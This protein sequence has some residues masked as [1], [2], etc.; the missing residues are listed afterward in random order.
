MKKWTMRV[1]KGGKWV[2]EYAF[3]PKN[4]FELVDEIYQRVEDLGEFEIAQLGI[5]GEYDPDVD[6]FGGTIPP[7]HQLN[8]REITMRVIIILGAIRGVIENQDDE[9]H[10]EID[11][12]LGFHQEYI[13]LYIPI[14]ANTD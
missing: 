9:L 5:E 2:D 12:W 13:P 1:K 4:L 11:E 7:F 14:S 6:P 3:D 10:Q 8:S